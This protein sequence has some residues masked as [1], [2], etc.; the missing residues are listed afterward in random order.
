MLN[1]MSP[2]KS[3]LTLETLNHFSDTST[4][5][6]IENYHDLK[7]SIFNSVDDLASRYLIKLHQFE[8]KCILYNDVFNLYKEQNALINQY[9]GWCY[10]INGKITRAIPVQTETVSIRLNLNYLNSIP[11]IPN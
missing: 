1:R 3:L 5:Q 9:Y 8:L 6:I 7:K 11:I 4:I 10:D 2:I